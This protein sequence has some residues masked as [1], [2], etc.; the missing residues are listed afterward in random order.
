MVHHY[1]A[2]GNSHLSF[3]YMGYDLQALAFIHVLDARKVEYGWRTLP[4]SVVLSQD[5]QKV[6]E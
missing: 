3:W 1:V 6:S 5:F 2:S 4:V